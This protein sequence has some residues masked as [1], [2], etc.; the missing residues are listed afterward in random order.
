VGPFF[1]VLPTVFE[2]R[3]AEA[4]QAY[5]RSFFPGYLIDDATRGRISGLLGK[6]DIGPM[7]RRLLLEADD[8][9]RRALVC[10]AMAASVPG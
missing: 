10:R 1:T 5:F 8:D 4:A 9:I 2:E 6:A 7:L 3:E